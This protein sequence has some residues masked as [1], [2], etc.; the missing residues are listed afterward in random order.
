ML[1]AVRG[2]SCD[3]TMHLLNEGNLSHVRCL[4]LDWR[5]LSSDVNDLVLRW[6]SVKMVED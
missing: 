6:T 5:D 1:G 4:N 3:V 2:R